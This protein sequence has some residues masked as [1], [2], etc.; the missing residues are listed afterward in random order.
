MKIKENKGNRGKLTWF[1]QNPYFEAVKPKFKRG[2][3]LEVRELREDAMSNEVF[4]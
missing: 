4:N 1:L 3:Y 2:I